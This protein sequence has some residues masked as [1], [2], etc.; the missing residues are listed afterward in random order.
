[1]A[2]LILNGYLQASGDGCGCASPAGQDS[3][4]RRL[5]LR[6]SPAYYQTIVETPSPIRVQTPGVPGASFVDLDVV[7]NL[8]GIEFLQ[9]RTEGGPFVLCID[10]GAAELTSDAITI[11]TGFV[12][13]ETMDV[14][15]DQNPLV[16]VTFQA[17]DQTLA[18]VVARINAAF[19]LAGLPT[20]RCEGLGL[21]QIVI[22]AIECGP[23]SS[24]TVGPA[25]A[26]PFT[27]LA[28]AGNGTH[29]TVQGNLLVEFPPW[30]DAPTRIQVSGQGSIS[31]LAAGRSSP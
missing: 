1:V 22:T 21:N 17:G 31:V 14:T 8:I 18:Q 11:P 26:I 27:T 6:C 28:A 4:T 2:N 5:S 20:P 12:G 9:A 30:P 16:T 10:A 25:P 15:I 23:D 7:A 3:A 13:G 29:L 19:A 24:V